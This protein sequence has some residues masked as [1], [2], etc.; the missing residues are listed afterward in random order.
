MS[1]HL[2]PEVL[3]DVSD[4]AL[5]AYWNDLTQNIARLEGFRATV[6]AEAERRD[7]EM[8]AAMKAK[9]DCFYVFNGCAHPQFC[10]DGCAAK[11]SPDCHPEK[12]SEK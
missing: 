1:Q 5:M 7:L 9:K 4:A 6:R 8:S 12:G 3:K 10:K 2:T 11:P